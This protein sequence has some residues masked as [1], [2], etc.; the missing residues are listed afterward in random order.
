V[1]AFTSRLMFGLAALGALLIGLAALRL[2]GG[3]DDELREALEQRGRVLVADDA[4]FVDLKLTGTELARLDSQ[5]AVAAAARGSDGAA[6]AQA[7]RAAAVDALAVEA[8]PRRGGRDLLSQLARYEH[9]AGL[10]GLHLSP[11]IA[12]YTHDLASELSPPLRAALLGVARGLLVGARPPR[13]SSFPEPI[14][15]LRHV[16]VM[17]L[18]RQGKVARLWRSARGSSLGRALITAAGVARERWAERAQAMG[19]P[20]ESRLAALTLEV[21][22]LQDDG[23]LGRRDP[24]FLQRAFKSEHG[25]GFEHKGAWRYLLPELM[26]RHATPLQAYAALF[27]ENGHSPDLIGAAEVRLYRMSVSSL[28]S[29][30]AREPAPDDGLS[31]VTDPGQVLEP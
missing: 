5:A 2:Y 7:M 6:L 4:P 17:L 19:G 14:R 20:L 24:A 26:I 27:E 1:P 13:I 31:E 18:L 9:V 16:E 10:R 3:V 25:V 12:V 22:L 28:V 21:S 8:A 30:P 11:R 29:G 15:R 23:T